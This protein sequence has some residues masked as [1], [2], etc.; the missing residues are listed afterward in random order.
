MFYADD[1]VFVG[2]WCDD[3][4]NTLVH[5]LECFFR[6]SGLRINMSK[7]K[8]MG[9]NVGDDKIKVAASKL[10]C[11]ILNTPFTYLG[12]YSSLGKS[13]W[14][15]FTNEIQL[16]RVRDKLRAKSVLGG[17][18]NI[19]TLT[20]SLNGS[21]GWPL[22]VFSLKLD[23]DPRCLIL[24]SSWLVLLVSYPKQL[25]FEE[26]RTFKGRLFLTDVV[27]DLVGLRNETSKEAANFAATEICWFDSRANIR[28]NSSR[29]AGLG[30]ILTAFHHQ[31]DEWKTKD[32][33]YLVVMKNRQHYVVLE[34]RMFLTNS[35]FSSMLRSNSSL[36]KIMWFAFRMSSLVNFSRISRPWS[37]RGLSG[38]ELEFYYK[39]DETSSSF[40]LPVRLSYQILLEVNKDL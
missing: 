5:V 27:S 12:E 36:A 39:S 1:A 25:L 13:N 10:G 20:P 26:K 35:S 22:Y 31:M 15:R 28:G 17:I 38:R 19:R 32:G 24:W 33:A 37:T 3:N 9:V 11:L 7:S 18:S 21:T 40:P 29:P 34:L 30:I 16:I 14:K 8:I 4:I 6:A 23:D 2:Q